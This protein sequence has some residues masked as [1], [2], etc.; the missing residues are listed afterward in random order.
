[1]RRSWPAGV[2]ILVLAPISLT[3][4]HAPSAS[5]SPPL[6]KKACH[7]VTKKVHGK[8]KRVRVC[9]ATA[10]QSPTPTASPALAKAPCHD[11]TKKV[12]GKKKRIR[13][14][15]TTHKPT[16]TP[17]PAPTETP[18]S[19]PEAG[20]TSTTLSIKNP[21]VV[22]VIPVNITDSSNPQAD[23]TVNLNQMQQ[24]LTDTKTFYASYGNRINLQFNQEPTLN[25][26][27]DQISTTDAPCSDLFVPDEKKYIYTHDWPNTSAD[28]ATAVMIYNQ[29]DLQYCI[30]NP[31]HSSIAGYTSYDTTRTGQVI[32]WTVI[33]DAW[34][35]TLLHHEVLREFG[36][37]Q[38][39]LASCDTPGCVPS[40]GHQIGSAG[41]D[42]G[43]DVGGSYGNGGLDIVNEL[44]LGLLG[45]SNIATQTSGI[46]DYTLEP[47]AQMDSGLK[48][49]ALPFKETN[50]QKDT[51]YISFAD[52]VAGTGD[53]NVAKPQVRVNIWDNSIIF[54]LA[55][56]DTELPPKNA[57]DTL[58]DSA[59][60]WTMTVEQVSSSSA[61]VRVVFGS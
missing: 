23:S 10:K 28:N 59:D 41:Y 61:V 14:C 52:P 16:P 36:G 3:Q 50:G 38:E 48:A 19:T 1:M 15:Q 58:T 12:H 22:D 53:S 57:G 17:T 31:V 20:L 25:L 2:L 13:V 9:R 5:A 26:T 24:Y 34:R 60:G 51:A 27:A 33:N 55:D 8:K 37:N 42:N 54:N 56:S 47:R 40:A 49:V 39:D 18:T 7:T 6:G 21:T 44:Y 43:D 46:Q 30:S 35:N 29:F 11:V 4:Q 45:P 32:A